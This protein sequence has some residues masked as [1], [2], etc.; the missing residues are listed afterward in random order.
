ML[1]RSLSRQ[2]LEVIAEIR[3]ISGKS[4]ILFPGRKNFFTPISD[5]TLL[6][7]IKILGYGGQVVPHGFRG[8]AS[9]ILNEYEFSSDAIERQLAHKPRNKVRRSYNH[10][11]HMKSRVQMMQWWG[12]YLGAMYQGVAIMPNHDQEDN[13]TSQKEAA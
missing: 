4:P 7:A 2:A 8:T 13:Q 12:D 1:F 9:T 6:K 10:A 11:A 3:R 5:V